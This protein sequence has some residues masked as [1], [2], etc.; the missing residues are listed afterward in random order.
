MIEL[1]FPNINANLATVLNTVSRILEVVFFAMLVIGHWQVFK[2]F[3]E[4]PWKALIPFYNLYIM[5]RYTWKRSAFWIYIGSS[6]SFTL[7]F[8]ISEAL[9]KIVPDSIWVSV[10]LLVSVPFGILSIIYTFLS[11]IRIAEAFGKGLLYGVGLTFFYEILVLVLGFG[12]AEYVCGKGEENSIPEKEG[13]K[14]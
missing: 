1:L 11:N 5:F 14:I 4:K 6:V 8:G 12:K 10:L 13:V 9:V 7:L 2:K 3:N